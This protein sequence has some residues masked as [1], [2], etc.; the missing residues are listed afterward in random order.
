[1][2]RG[3]HALLIARYSPIVRHEIGGTFAPLC[4]IAVGDRSSAHGVAI[5]GASLSSQAYG[6]PPLLSR[7]LEISVALFLRV[8]VV[9]P[10][11]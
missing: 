10:A 8:I 4:R 7:S 2:D 1:M 9:T 6:R 5:E 3:I 11:A